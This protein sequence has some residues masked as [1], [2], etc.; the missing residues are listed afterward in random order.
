MQHIADADQ[1]GCPPKDWAVMS[2]GSMH[3][4]PSNRSHEHKVH[5][6]LPKR[7]MQ[8]RISWDLVS[9]FV[10]AGFLDV[11]ALEGEL[12]RIHPEL[13]KAGNQEGIIMHKKVAT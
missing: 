4:T 1:Y 3:S 7:I 10:Y 13:A 6:T 5:S 2:I 9:G 8:L 11:E 12:S